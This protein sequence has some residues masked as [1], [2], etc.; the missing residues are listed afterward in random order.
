[1]VPGVINNGEDNINGII[2]I[3]VNLVYF[4]RSIDLMPALFYT[5][6]VVITLQF[7]C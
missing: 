3:V 5:T 7:L 2:I 1:M 4:C 6:L